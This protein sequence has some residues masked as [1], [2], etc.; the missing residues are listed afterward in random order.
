MVGALSSSSLSST[1]VQCVLDR[2]VVNHDTI[3]KFTN[4][5]LSIFAVLCGKNRGVFVTTDSDPGNT[6]SC[7][8]LPP[9][10]QNLVSDS[11]IPMSTSNDI[12][13]CVSCV[14]SNTTFRIFCVLHIRQEKYHPHPSDTP[15]FYLFFCYIR[16][17]VQS[18]EYNG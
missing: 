10:F 16:F 3:H 4:I 9:S 6:Y 11:S 14:S 17:A 13:T 2:S 5:G 18:G 8:T 7:L 15:Y 1:A 12:G